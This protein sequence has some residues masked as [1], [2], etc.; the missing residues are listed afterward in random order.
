MSAVAVVGVPVHNGEKHLEAALD[1]LLAQARGD[2]RLVVVDDASTDGSQEILRRRLE[3][4]GVPSVRNETRVGL[5]AAWRQAFDLAL[6]M[7]PSARYFAWGSDH[8]VWAPDWLGELVRALSKRPSAVLAH[9]LVALIDDA[10]EPVKRR[11]SRFE[12]TGMNEPL[13][14]LRAVVTEA[15]AGDLVYGLFRVDALR[16]CGPF[17]S[18]LVPDR[19]L[20]ARLALEGEFVQVQRT[21]W[22]RRRRAGVSMSLTRQRQTLWSGQPPLSAY[23]PWAVQH[24]LTLSRS[25]GSAARGH[26]VR[27]AIAYLRATR[28]N[29]AARRAS[30]RGRTWRRRRSRWRQRLRMLYLKAG[31]GRG[32]R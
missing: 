29:A 7:E 19:L 10:G 27:A 24:A 32:G 31:A 17:P 18:V 25:R 13:D 11:L 4:L 28:E 2:L 15:R 1:S 8:D 30:R 5:V 16:A 6:A 3:P 20:L 9:P 14:R 23:V 12:T 21:L 26:G 22:Y